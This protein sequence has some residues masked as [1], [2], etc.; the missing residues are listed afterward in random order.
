M[1]P[2]SGPSRR[3]ESS[4]ITSIGVVERDCT[5][6]AGGAVPEAVAHA[7]IDAR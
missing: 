4:G 1:A 7:F 6:I 2:R 5:A 3:L